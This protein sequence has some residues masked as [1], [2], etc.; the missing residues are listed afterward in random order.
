MLRA[1][2]RAGWQ[3]RDW[4]YRFHYKLCL[5]TAH[6]VGAKIIVALTDSGFTARMISRHKPKPLILVISR[7]EKTCNQTCVFFRL[8]AGASGEV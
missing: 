6:D 7:N 2:V 4:H 3:W 1:M 5:K 8:S